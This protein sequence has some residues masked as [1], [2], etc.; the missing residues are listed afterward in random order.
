MSKLSR[1]IRILSSEGLSAL[2]KQSTFYVRNSILTHGE[3]VIYEF[4]YHNQP[5]IPVILPKLPCTYRAITSVDEFDALLGQG[6]QFGARDFRPKLQKGA[7]VFCLFVN[8]RLASEVWTAANAHARRVIDPIPFKVDFDKG[9]ICN[10]VRFTNPKYRRNGLAEYLYAI[11]LPYL[12]ENFVKG[13]AS[14]NVNNKVARRINE[15]FYGKI[16]ARGHY[17]RFIRWQYWKEKSG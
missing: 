16:I 11:R 3:Y 13:K 10:G 12:K 1:I 4:D 5:E 7:V 17:F 8:N 15:M 2:L 6:Y 14:V 9:E